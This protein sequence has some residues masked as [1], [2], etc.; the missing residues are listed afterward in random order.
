MDLRNFFAELRR[1]NVYR[2][3]VGYGVVA[4]LLIQAADILLP[5]FEAP[6][7][8]MKALVTAAALGF[9]V[10]IIL[11]WAFEITPE[12]IVRTG[13]APANAPPAR[14]TGRKLTALIT[15]LAC[16]AA[17]LFLLQRMRPEQSGDA[18]RAGLSIAVL[19]LVNGSGDPAQEYFSDGLS[20]ELINSLGHIPS[21]G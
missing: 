21:C 14:H 12:G 8:A 1:R 16:L 2:V 19:P 7:W 13:D 20:E 15:V 18:P 6:A 3:A 5:T 9:P 11:A 10:A 17:G 4:W